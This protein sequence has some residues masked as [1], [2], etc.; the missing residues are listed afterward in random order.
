[1]TAFVPPN[2]Y[3]PTKAQTG[4]DVGDLFTL[5]NKFTLS[6]QGKLAQIR[7]RTTSVS[8]GDM[9]EM[10]ML[11]NHLSQMSEMATSVVGATNS[12]ILSMTRNLKQ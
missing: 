2:D 11:M 7:D 9:F 5:V 6:V 4:V 1:M 12:A 8:I 10:Q 3:N